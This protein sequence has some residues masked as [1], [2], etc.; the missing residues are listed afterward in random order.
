MEIKIE[1]RIIQ[2]IFELLQE[3]PRRPGSYQAERLFN[4]NLGRGWIFLS[5]LED[6]L[7]LMDN[8]LES[9]V[10]RIHRLLQAIGIPVEEAFYRPRAIAND[11][12][13]FGAIRPENFVLLLINLERMAFQIDAKR[14]VDI[15]LPSILPRSKRIFS[16]AELEIF[17]YAKSRHKKEDVVL[18]SDSSWHYHERDKIIRL[19]NGFKLSRFVDPDNC[20]TLSL[21]IR[22]PKYRNQPQPKATVCPDCGFEWRKGD[23][24]SSMLHRKEHKRRMTWLKP[25]PL[26][27]MLSELR[28]IG[29]D[30]ELVTESSPIW[31]HKEMYNR[32]RAFKRELHYDFIQWNEDGNVGQEARG[33]LFT[34][35]KGEIVGACAF[36]QRKEKQKRWGLQ[37]I[38]FCPIERRKGHLEKRWST[39]RERFGD[40]LVE[41]PVSNA[42]KT[43]LEKHGDTALLDNDP[44][45]D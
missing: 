21:R 16:L 31:K 39:L 6:I 10:F 24:E 43:F 33:F 35:E 18:F 25:C 41:P 12:I 22:A 30:A 13:S 27:E 8:R 44:E 36:R 9:H 19:A 32:A 4:S 14:F 2:H 11:A 45:R 26:P 7:S 29:M 42:M 34:G 17:W 28:E 5:D 40:F 37:W 20:E 38:W 1:S 23:R 15:L 3:E